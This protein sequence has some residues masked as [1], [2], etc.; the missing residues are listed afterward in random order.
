MQDE[1]IALYTGY[2]RLELHQTK[3]FILVEK[4]Q[5]NELLR[6]KEY[7]RM[8][9]K[10]MDCAI[11]IGKLIGIKKAIVGSFELAA[12]TCK[13]SGQLINIDNS[14]NWAE[15]TLLVPSE[16]LAS[17]AMGLGYKT[18]KIAKNS[19]AECMEIAL[20]DIFS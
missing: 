12:D 2:L 4:N 17:V 3:S 15:L 9:C 5:I 18:I 14:R 6:E 8:D 1:D 19:S 13:I 11:E 7:D 16:R 10:T 20:N